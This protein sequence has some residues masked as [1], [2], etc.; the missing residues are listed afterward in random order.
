MVDARGP[1]K[2]GPP[3][4]R[5]RVGGKAMEACRKFVMRGPGLLLAGRKRWDLYQAKTLRREVEML[6][7]HL[8]EEGKEVKIRC[9]ISFASTFLEIETDYGQLATI[10]AR[11]KRAIAKR[12]RRE[13][14]RSLHRATGDSF[15]LLL[16]AAHIR[17]QTLSGADA[18]SVFLGTERILKLARPFWAKHVQEE[19]ALMESIRKITREP[20]RRPQASENIV[21]FGPLR[22]ADSGLQKRPGD[23]A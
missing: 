17:A 1:E 6:I 5:G 15:G 4:I 7:Q 19:A 23:T 3:E 16:L 12:I 9:A 20:A 18:E 2:N 21:P 8:G 14:Y 11:E 10:S 22:E 13:G